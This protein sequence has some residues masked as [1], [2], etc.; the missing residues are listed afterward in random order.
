MSSST[1][2]PAVPRRSS[3]EDEYHEDPVADLCLSGLPAGGSAAA[4]GP[5]R[6]PDVALPLHDPDWRFEDGSEMPSLSPSADSGV[7]DAFSG[8]T[9][10]E[11]EQQRQQW[12]E[13]LAR[14]ANLAT[15]P[16]VR[17][18]AVACNHRVHLSR[19]PPALSN[20]CSNPPLRYQ[21]TGAA[22]KSTGEKASGLF[23]G[24]GAK[25]SEARESAAFKT[26]EERMGTMVNSVKSK[27]STS[28][29]NSTQ[30]FDEA[31]RE[32]EAAQQKQ[33]AAAAAPP[34][35]GGEKPQ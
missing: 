15:R 25:I 26:V 31:L 14:A 17:S 34:A 30:S 3:A 33:A 35:G 8:L 4:S 12:K 10:E 27:V 18:Y 2:W 19:L 20:R 1:A 32:A 24:L 11:Q 21:R 28:H 29:S 22:L 16:Q 5:T 6:P 23:A 9:P 7:V 13:E